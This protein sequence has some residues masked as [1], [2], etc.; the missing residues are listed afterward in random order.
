MEHPH[1]PR[2]LLCWYLAAVLGGLAWAAPVSADSEAAADLERG[3]AIYQRLCAACHGDQ[4]QGVPDKHPAP[5]ATDLAESVLVRRIDETMPEDDPTACAGEDARAVARYVRATFPAQ[6]QQAARAEDGPALQ[7]LTVAEYR[8][9]MADLLASFEPRF[10]EPYPDERGVRREFE[11]LHPTEM[12]GGNKRKVYHEDQGH[13]ILLELG[14]KPPRDDLDRTERMQVFWVGS[15][16]AEQTGTYEFVIRSPNGVRFWFNADDI[17]ARPQIDAEVVSGRGVRELRCEVFLLAGW[18]YPL[19]IQWMIMAKEPEASLELLWQV[20]GQ[21]LRR[22][23]HR[24]LLPRLTPPVPVVSTPFPAEDASQGYERGTT[25]SAAWQEATARAAV[26]AAGLVARKLA[27]LDQDKSDPA[28]RAARIRQLCETFVARALRRPL[29]DKTRQ[30]FVGDIFAELPEAE[31]AARRVVLLTLCSARFLYPEAGVAA[32]DQFDVAARLARVLWNSLPDQ[33]LAD[34]AARGELS[35]RDAI[36]AQ[37]RRMIADRRA[38]TRLQGFFHHWLEF[39]R[40]ASVAKDDAVYPEF[41]AAL[42]DDL[43]L[44]LELFLDEVVWSDRSDYRE[45]L[46][47]RHLLLNQRLAGLYG[48]QVSAEAADEFVR[49]ALPAEQRS[50]VITHPFLLTLLAYHNNTSPIHRGVFIARNVVGRQLKPPPNAIEFQDVHF[51]P[52]LTMREKVTQ[53]T[54]EDACMA[55]HR[56]INPLGFSLE[57]YDGLGRWRTQERERPIDPVSEFTD[58]AGDPLTLRGARD[59]AELAAGSRLAR[60][61]FIRQMFQYAVREDTS[62]F[63]PNVLDGLETMFDASGCHIRH[64]LAEIAVVAASHGLDAPASPAG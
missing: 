43:R 62:V 46:L 12:D 39:D 22:V 24:L 7:R 50:G 3:A 27:A 61:A 41:D 33:Q 51:D 25:V 42:L 17:E 35:H 6:A 16:L 21:S 49:V 45:L 34:A 53:L 1:S 20:P 38:R 30:R 13:E 19:R 37:A 18:A 8:Q 40:A 5:L 47:S 44:S 29:D 32:P 28:A 55:C 26:E 57:R 64:L 36:R 59:V 4:G 2:A 63:G 11:G 10:G 9:S 48:G 56:T 31:A 15:V 52:A 23:P 54:R 14:D 58:D 60:R